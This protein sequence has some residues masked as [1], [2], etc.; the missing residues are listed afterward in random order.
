MLSAHQFIYVFHI[1]IVA[2]ILIYLGMCQCP[3]DKCNHYI[4]KVAFIFGVSVLLY[5]AYKL[6]LTFSKSA[7]VKESFAD[8]Q[9]SSMEYEQAY[10]QPNAPQKRQAA[11]FEHSYPSE[12]Y[13]EEIITKDL[14]YKQP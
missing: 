2:P 11:N 12:R 13:T 9:E 8:L 5:H 7:P 14:G 3:G 4:K 10:R 6:Y 1:L